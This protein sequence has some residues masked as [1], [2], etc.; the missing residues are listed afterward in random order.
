MHWYNCYHSIVGFDHKLEKKSDLIIREE[1]GKQDR[2]KMEVERMPTLHWG[3]GWKIDNGWD[4]KCDNV[5]ELY[6]FNFKI[7]VILLILN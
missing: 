1:L 5:K 7:L 6:Y 3:S 4:K 2:H